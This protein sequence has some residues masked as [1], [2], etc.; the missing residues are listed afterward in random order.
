MNNE[1]T[2]KGSQTNLLGIS[3]PVSSIDK[4]SNELYVNSET[5]PTF[6]IHTTDDLFVPVEN[7][8]NY[9]LALKKNQ[10]PAELHLYEKGGHG[11]GLGTKGTSL[12]WTTDCENWLR[13]QSYLKVLSKD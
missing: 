1:I 3:P 9:Y 13:S 10:V 7:S 8:I 11:F 4:F 5:P 12:F 6:I 2:H